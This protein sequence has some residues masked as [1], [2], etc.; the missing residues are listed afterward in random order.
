MILILRNLCIDLLQWVLCHLWLIVLCLQRIALWQHIKQCCRQFVNGF[1]IK[2]L[3]LSRSDPMY[4]WI[5]LFVSHCWRMWWWRKCT[6]ISLVMEGERFQT[7]K[8]RN[9]DF[10]LVKCKHIPDDFC[11]KYSSRLTLMITF[12]V[13]ERTFW[14]LP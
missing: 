10:L 11:S 7:L 9:S 6:L 2:L 4:I 5:I 14:F 13:T 12:C 3:F 8:K 1:L